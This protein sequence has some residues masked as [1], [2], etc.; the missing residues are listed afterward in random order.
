MSSPKLLHD[1]HMSEFLALVDQMRARGV[2]EFSIGQMSVR[3]SEAGGSDLVGA[4]DQA[5]EN[6]KQE[7]LDMMTPQQREEFEIKLADRLKFGSA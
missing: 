1:L 2:S 4:M 6:A 7:L 5:Y 3:F